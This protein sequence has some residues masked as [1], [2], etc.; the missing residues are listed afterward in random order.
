MLALGNVG[1][2][3]T[4]GHQLASDGH[5][6]DDVLS[7]FDLL[8][9]QSRPVRTMLQQGGVINL[10]SGWADGVLTVTSVGGAFVLLTTGNVVNAVLTATNRAA[11]QPNP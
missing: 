9:T 5:A 11:T 6:L 1:D 7:W 10:A 4:I 3:H 8:A 2:L